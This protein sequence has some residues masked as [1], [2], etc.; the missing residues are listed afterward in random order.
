[1]KRFL[2]VFLIVFGGILLLLFLLPFIFK[3]KIEAKVKTA[4]NEQVNATVTWDDF[5]LS[6]FRSFPNLGMGLD[7]LLIVNQAPFEGDTLVYVD[8]FALSVDVWKAIKGDGIEIK[9]I[10]INRPLINLK[11]N[12]DSIANWDIMPP[13]E[14]VVVEDTTATSDFA[15]QLEA[16]VIEG[17]SLSYI[18][19]TMSFSTSLDGMNA[20]LKGDMSAD[21]TNL[22]VL[23]H[24]DA[25]NLTYEDVRYI[26]NSVL[27]LNAGIGA[28]LDKMI[29]TFQ[30]NELNFNNIP[31]FMEGTLAML[32]EGYDMDLRMA[33][34]ETQFKTI[35]A[36]VPK[37]YLKDLDG[38]KTSGSFILE[39]TAKGI[40][41]DTDHLPAFNVLLDVKDGYIQYPDLPKSLENIRVHFLLTN[42]GGTMDQTVADIKSFHF[43]LEKNP[44]DATML[45]TN[46]VS[47]AAFK[48]G[49][50]GTIDLGSLKQALPM[51]SVEMAGVIRADVTLE[52][53]YEMIDKEQ[54]ESLKANGDIVLT[55]FD[56]KSPDFPDGIKISEASMQITPRFVELKSFQSQFGQSDFALQGKL[57][58]YLAYALKDGMLKGTL[59]QHSKYINADEL[60]GLSAEETTETPES[61]E[62]IGKVLVPSNLNFV[63]N[64]KVDKLLYDKLEMTNA[65]GTVKIQDSRVILEGLKTDLLRGQMV[66][67]GEYNT[68]DTLKPFVDFNLIVSSVDINQA[69]QSIS[70]LESL[71][72][73][74]KK[75]NGL[76]SSN[77]KFN[78]LI[79]DEFSP[80]LTTINGG[81]LLKS[82]NVEVSGSKV[83]GALTSM[84]KNDKY[85]VASIKDLLVNF[86]IE[87][88]NLLVKPF[89][90]NVFDKKLNIGGTQGV[91]QSMDFNIKMPVTRSEISNIAG[92]LGGLPT[93]GDDIMVGVKI[94][95]SVTDPKINFV[96]DDAK[97]QIKVELKEEVKKEAE[98][99][100][101]K[102]MSDPEVKKKVDDVKDKL[103]K[104]F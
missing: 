21:Y 102:V 66:M 20:S 65:K 28:D 92:F 73:I 14:E 4:I 56:F 39:A 59:E 98:K 5:S 34:R 24:V 52:G 44:F 32:D 1:M 86:A 31:L 17:G 61:T 90:V 45:I 30:D 62:P 11:V 71:V 13:V 27:D 54:Y 58:N 53:N 87:N 100:V 60:M 8:N 103:K 47:N 64:C 7:G 74:A 72:P 46:P 68:Q 69:V 40:F 43:E 35:L 93:S 25:F 70:M 50:K 97:S 26:N 75:A 89:D 48:G 77:F 79:D 96:L 41:I 37:V 33:A 3:G 51:D 2:K 81:G 15:M 95:G 36:L 67:T 23:A 9:S 38:L 22:E 63:M 49:M 19:Q 16:F 82:N 101:E 29:F 85:K 91:D 6:M 80:V 10:L 57:E 104:L 94:G 12:A 83:Q 42:P 18:D 55:A 78:S 88:G 76:V 99:A 84:L